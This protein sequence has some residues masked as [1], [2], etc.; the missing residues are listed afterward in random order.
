[1]KGH[2]VYVEE[3]TVYICNCKAEFRS[4]REAEA[5]LRNPPPAK[6]K[7]PRPT[8]PKKRAPR[9][10]EDKTVTIS[11]L[12]VPGTGRESAWPSTDQ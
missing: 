10:T 11:E 2:S 6:S 1:M 7:G 12:T 4:M 9:H 3:R 8:K 5:H